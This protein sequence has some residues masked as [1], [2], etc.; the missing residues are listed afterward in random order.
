[1]FLPL[2]LLTLF[3]LAYGEQFFETHDF[4]EEENPFEKEPTSVFEYDRNGIITINGK[5]GG[6]FRLPGLPHEVNNIGNSDVTW[7]FCVK[8]NSSCKHGIKVCIN[9]YPGEPHNCDYE[10]GFYSD[11]AGYRIDWIDTKSGGKQS[12]IFKDSSVNCA[13]HILKIPHQAI[14]VG[15]SVPNT[16]S[17]CDAT[18]QIV[19][20]DMVQI[21][22]ACR[23]YF[24]A[25]RFRNVLGDGTQILNARTVAAFATT[26]ALCTTEQSDCFDS[27][28][29]ALHRIP[30]ANR[31]VSREHIL[32]LLAPMGSSS[33]DL[34]DGLWHSARILIDPLI[35]IN[36][37]T[38]AN[39]WSR[40][41]AT[42]FN[43]IVTSDQPGEQ[44]ARLNIQ[45]GM[46]QRITI[47]QKIWHCSVHHKGV[48]EV[49]S[50]LFK[51]WDMSLTNE[52]YAENWMNHK[53]TLVFLK[54]SA[55]SRSIELSVV[56][57]MILSFHLFFW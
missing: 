47:L 2:I 55:S 38:T 7:K 23:V 51:N 37:T 13:E 49:K 29:V 3:Y 20:Q 52:T 57:T 32:G 50:G 8:T 56:L 42:T 16:E 48:Y 6:F 33:P 43:D 39:G 14:L 30:L 36:D 18:L 35:F 4:A 46:P 26:M 27:P 25:K 17:H 22:N 28:S 54:D 40:Q 21:L 45:C 11:G 44:T 12:S 53:Q 19:S 10:V 5:F 31:A 1:M 15:G 9:D 24:T 41:T 34:Q